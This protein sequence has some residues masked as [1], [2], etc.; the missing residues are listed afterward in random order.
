VLVVRPL[1]E[2][3]DNA[4][5]GLDQCFDRSSPLRLAQEIPNLYPSPTTAEPLVQTE[6]IVRRVAGRMWQKS[7]IGET[8]AGPDSKEAKVSSPLR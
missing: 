5:D 7:N 3:V 4:A 8:V 6:R 1:I 2:R